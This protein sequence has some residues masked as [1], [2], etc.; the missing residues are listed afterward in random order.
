M[1]TSAGLYWQIS[2][3][4]HIVRD[5]SLAGLAFT[6]RGFV[7]LIHVFIVPRRQLTMQGWALCESLKHNK[8]EFKIKSKLQNCVT[9]QF[10][11]VTAT[12]LQIS[13]AYMLHYKSEDRTAALLPLMLLNFHLTLCTKSL[14]PTSGLTVLAL[15]WAP[16]I[17]SPYLIH[18]IVPS[19]ALSK[20]TSTPS[21]YR[22][23]TGSFTAQHLT[24]PLFGP[25]QYI[26]APP[27]P[28]LIGSP[29]STATVTTQQRSYQTPT[30]YILPSKKPMNTSNT[31]STS[32]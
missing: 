20:N 15:L 30:L 7:M 18:L 22:S 27:T 2:L 16:H 19:L 17:S 24:V 23:I 13:S 31:P 26:W 9:L 3:T 25:H 28:S 1:T 10:F 14:L 32:T 12:R 21:G 4:H 6:K 5:S 11:Y 29:T 8:S